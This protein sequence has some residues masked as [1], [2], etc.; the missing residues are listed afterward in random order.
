MLTTLAL[1]LGVVVVAMSQA[2]GFAALLVFVTLTRALGQS[3]L[4]VVSLAMV[5]KWFRRRLTKAMAIYALVMSV[6]FMVGVSR[7]RRRRAVAGLAGRVGRDRRGARCWCWRRWR[8]C[9]VG[10]RRRQSGWRSTAVWRG[11]D[12]CRRS[13]RR[14]TLA[15]ALRSPAF[16]VFAL[17]SAAYGLVA[18]GIGLFNESILAE[19]GFAPDVY[20]PRSR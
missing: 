4:S 5:G 17:A 14:A 6:G 9:S 8:G 18:S 13:P 19:R 20:H 15:R 2:V 11:G 1:L 16:W 12:D 7:G 10:R 3:A